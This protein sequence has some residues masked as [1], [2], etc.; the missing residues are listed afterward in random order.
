MAVAGLFFNA[1]AP[2]QSEVD[3]TKEIAHRLHIPSRKRTRRR[4]ALEYSME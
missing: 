3:Q 4:A 2:A 1:L